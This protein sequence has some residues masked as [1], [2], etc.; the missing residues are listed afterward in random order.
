[1]KKSIIYL[2]ISATLTFSGCD[3]LDDMPYDWAQPDDIFTNEQNYLKPINQVYAYIPEGFNHVGNAFLDAATNDGISTIIDSDIHKLSRGYVTS[4]NPIEECWNKSY[5]GI[6]QAIFARKYLREADLVLQNK[7]EEDIQA[8]KDTYCAE[9]ECLQALFEFNLLR[10]YGGFPIVDRIY[11]VDDPELQTKARDSFKD[12]VNHIV[13]LCESAAAVLKVDPEGGN[14]SYGRMTKGMALA[15]KA[16]TL[17]YAA[18][19]LYNRT[20]NNDPLLGYTDGSDV[21]ERWKLAAKAC[22]DVINL[23]A[24][25]TISPNGNKKYNLIALTAAKTYDKIFIN[26]NPNPE[27]ILFYTAAKDNALENRHYPPTISKDQGGGTVPSQQLIDAFTMKDGSDYTHSS[28]G[29]SMYTNRDPRLAAIIGYDGSVYGKNTIY[30]RISDNTTIDGL[31]QVKNRSTNT[32]YYLAKFLDKTLNFGQA[33]VGTVFHLFPMIRLSDI[34]LSYAEAMHHAYGM[35]ADP[36]GYGL[37]AIE[38]IQKIRTRAGFGTNDKFLN[39]VTDNNFME[40]VKQER[41]I[42]L[43]FE[44]HRYF[45]LRRW[46]DG[47]QLREPIIGMKVEE[48]AS[49]LHYTR[50][51]VDEARNFKDYMYYHPIPLK[52]IKESPS[53]QQNPGW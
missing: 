6:Q 39:G 50:I 5:N 23:N 9:T 32:G 28:D 26:A 31:N 21:T 45:D 1:M 4:S 49:G 3:Y 10:H 29:A 2:T 33:N 44:E 47:N 51:T 46:M 43:C 15:I 8:F 40:K 14:G 11:E 25:G 42:E 17:L 13:Q 22:A 30:T 41:R 16:K 20:D 18:S 7:T 37:T 38:A 34:L 24:D 27:Y 19:P 35:N 36:E 12:C 52:V 53:I 48:N